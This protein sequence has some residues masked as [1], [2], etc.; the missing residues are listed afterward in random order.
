MSALTFDQWLSDLD[1]LARA[2]GCERSYV[3]QTGRECWQA[4]YDDGITPAEAWA[5]EKDAA[6]SLGCFEVAE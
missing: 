1:A 6:A 4:P 2:E 5:D 3:E